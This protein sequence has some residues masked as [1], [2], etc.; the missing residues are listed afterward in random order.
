MARD[1]R[2]AEKLPPRDNPFAAWSARFR[3]TR[4]LSP[5]TMAR[6]P[7]IAAVLLAVVIGTTMWLGFAYRQETAAVQRTLEVEKQLSQVLTTVQD[8]ETSNRG[9]IL[10]GNEIYLQDYNRAATQIGG[11]LDDL[12]TLIADNPRQQRSLAS[13]RPVIQSGFERLREGIELRRTQGIEPA[14]QYIQ[15][16]KGYE[17]MLLVRTG[18]V[19]LQKV[20]AE[21]LRERTA[22]ARGLILA[23]SVGAA[24]G[25][26]LVIL[27]VAGWIWNQR[28]DALQLA[29]E[30]AE[31]Q[32]AEAQLRQMQKIEAVGQLTGGIAHDFNNMLTIVISGLSLMRRRL[33]AGNTDVLDVADAAIDGAHRAAALTS[34]L[35]A[36]ARQQPLEPKPLDVNRLIGGMSDM[37]NR[38]LGETIA[39]DTI[40]ATDLWAVHVDPPQLESAL[41]NLCVN[42]RDAMPASGKLTIETSNIHL[43]E[44]ARHYALAA[45]QYVLIAVSDTGTGMMPDVLVR[46]FDPFFTTKEEGKGTGLGLSQV[47]GFVKQSGGHVQIYSEPDRGTSIEI[48]LPRLIEINPGHTRGATEADAKSQVAPASH[49]Q[50]ILLVEDDAGI[51]ELTESMLLELGYKVIAADGAAAALLK[52]AAHPEIAL[53]FTDIVMPEVDGHQLADQATARRPALKVLFTTGFARTDGELRPGAHFIAKPFTVDQLSSKVRAA[54]MGRPEQEEASG[55]SSGFHSN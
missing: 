15:G 6:L 16:N 10:T 52:L 44:D 21:L 24:G 18:I 25:I 46:A 53:L 50:L 55:L 1:M 3:M 2:Q 42:A 36:F 20:E 47:H 8:A 31:R 48:Y 49:N 30:T 51:R 35:M 9:F 5:R 17:L 11:E 19:Q 26:T 38:T 23:T 7:E 33:A 22:T 45:G 41:L 37:I 32:Q 40:L 28:R 39:L 43:E 29:A 4:T 54:L 34:R 27:A 12:R 14:I 13:L